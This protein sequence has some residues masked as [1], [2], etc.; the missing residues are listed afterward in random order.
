VVAGP[1]TT[2]A[3]VSNSRLMSLAESSLLMLRWWR[4]LRICLDGVDTKYDLGVPA[5]DMTFPA[6]WCLPLLTHTL[7]PAGS[8]DKGLTLCLTLY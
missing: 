2:G 1:S 5:D 8:T 4:F 7:V 6:I 3:D